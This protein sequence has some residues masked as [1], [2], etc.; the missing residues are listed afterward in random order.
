MTISTDTAN[1]T[2]STLRMPTVYRRTRLL[3]NRPTGRLGRPVRVV[4]PGSSL[5]RSVGVEVLREAGQQQHAP[6]IGL[7]IHQAKCA[8]LALAFVA[9]PDQAA[10]AHGV[11]E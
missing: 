7:N 2:M 6:H 8:P 9:Q 4:S 1:V 5:A 10:H 3:P 11:T